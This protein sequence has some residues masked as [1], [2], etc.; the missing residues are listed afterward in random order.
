MGGKQNP[1]ISVVIPMYNCEAYVNSLCEGLENQTF[2]DF[3]VICVNDGSTDNTRSLVEEFCKKD[4]RFHFI[5]KE[6]G[7]AGSARNAGIE[8][9]TGKYM[10]FL[11]ADDEYHSNLL[12]E[13]YAAAEKHQA[14]EVLC[15][16]Q[17]HNYRDNITD[18]ELGFDAT[19]FPDDISIATD[20]VSQLFCSI[21]WAPWS[22]LYRKDLIDRY[23]LRFST[24]TISNDVFFIHAYAAITENIVGIHK[25]LIWAR[26]YHN[27]ESITSGRWNHAE[28]T[29][30]VLE[31][32]GSWLKENNLLDKYL[33]TYRNRCIYSIMYNIGFPYNEAF[34]SAVVKHICENDVW[35]GMTD[36]DFYKKYW[37]RFDTSD[38]QKQLSALKSQNHNNTAYA[39]EL[40]NRLHYVRMMEK[41]AYERYGR[42]LN[43][44]NSYNEVNSLKSQIDKLQADNKKKTS[45][46]EKTKKD[47]IKAN[48]KIDKVKESWNYKTGY[49]ITWAPKK[50]YYGLTGK[51]KTE[52]NSMDVKVSVILPV[53]NVEKYI[54][55]CLDSMISQSLKELEFIFIDDCSRDG[56]VAIIEEYRKKD[57]RIKILRNS[58]NMGPG[59]SRNRGIDVARGEF[60]TFA[61]PD[62]W[63]SPNCYELLYNKVKASG[64]DMI[65]GNVRKID[66]AGKDVTP[67]PYWSDADPVAKKLSSGLPLY[68]S[69]STNHFSILFSRKIFDDKTIRYGNT[70][71]GEDGIFLLR[72]FLKTDSISLCDEVVYYYYQR[73]ASLTDTTVFARHKSSLGALKEKAN[74]LASHGFTDYDYYYLQ[75]Y[76]TYCFN[77]LRKYYGDS[78]ES[79]LPELKE[80]IETFEGIINRVPEPNR[81]YD[82]L[83]DY[84]E[85][86]KL[87]AN[88]C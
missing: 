58:S 62:D 34:A 41:E 74:I 73:A 72:V 77:T 64:K 47:L 82:E 83:P 75:R 29:V 39:Q 12:E 81:I 20:S 25:D 43:P 88:H 19:V 67:S 71:T 84:A 76:S 49:F 3:E 22:A 23:N 4:S 21:N 5:D 16:Y 27:N 7:G 68:V 18:K 53:Y 44:N 69:L 63:V 14:D 56:S 66:E 46:L 13:M 60:L 45:Q 61:D 57:S 32:L 35:K 50:I 65:K 24:T 31:E 40:S 33:D 10:M 6:N 80:Y 37:K 38:I 36:A 59:P 17:Q 28:E 85:I 78:P 42:V 54:R 87:I 15:Q 79:K 52:N 8:V 30:L 9:A 70:R 2:T 1:A 26:R 11:D 86:K 48:N 51:K 55:R